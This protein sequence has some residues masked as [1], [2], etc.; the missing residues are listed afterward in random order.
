M[1]KRS[2]LIALPE[3]EGIFKEIKKRTSKKSCWIREA[4][5]EKVK[6][7]K[8]RLSNAKEEKA[9][10]IIPINVRMDRETCDHLEQIVKHEK[11]LWKCFTSKSL[12]ISEA[13]SEKLQNDV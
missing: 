9:E 3:A 13:I 2:N 4:I 8:E 6:C 12:W 5:R 7:E 11:S 10:E 1:K